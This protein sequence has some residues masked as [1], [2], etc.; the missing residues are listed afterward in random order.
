MHTIQK[1]QLMDD[2]KL[3]IMFDTHEVFVF[4]LKPYLQ[5]PAFK[6]LQDEAFFKKVCIHPQTHTI[7][8]NNEIDFCAEAL[9][10]KYQS[11]RKKYEYRS[12]K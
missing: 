6:A 2:Y 8:W 4:N 5:K 10:L 11:S 1:I 9:Y 3:R 7:S 12:K